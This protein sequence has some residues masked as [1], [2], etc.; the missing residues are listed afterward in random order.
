M[1]HP[2]QYGGTFHRF[3][4]KHSDRIVGMELFNRGTDYYSKR[5]YDGKGY[6]DEALANK[7]HLGAGGGQ[8]NHGKD[9]G[10]M[11]DYRMAVLAT[12]KTRAAIFDALKD[13][14]FFSTLDKSIAL[15]FVCNGHEM[16]S[17]VKAGEGPSPVL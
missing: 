10:T 4:F 17:F 5:G 14:R 16:G 15:S 11:N 1:N 12:S 13:R 3:N 9:W 8:D 7:W 6:Y 2:G